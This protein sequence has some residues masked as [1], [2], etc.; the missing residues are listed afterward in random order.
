MDSI[1]YSDV[2]AQLAETLKRLEVR[3][4]AIYISRRGQPAGVLMSVA[5]YRRLQGEPA[6]FGSAYITW[7]K[8]FER[9]LAAHAAQEWPDPFADV[10]D[11][12]ADGGRPPFEWPQDLP[13][14]GAALP[15]L[16][17]P[18]K[19]AKAPATASRRKL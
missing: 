15:N 4:E 7:R 18:Q 3:E 9:D 12:S 19:A 10:P 11:R 1:P 8:R 2:R 5:Q 13:E 14:D 6:D 17:T 16:P